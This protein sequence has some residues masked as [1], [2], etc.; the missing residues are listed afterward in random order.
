MSDLPASHS[1][2]FAEVLGHIQQTRQRVFAQANT[3]L[4][5][6]YWRMKQFSETYQGNAELSTLLRE[7][8]WSHNLAIFSRCKT[9]GDELYARALNLMSHETYSLY[10]P[11]E[12]VEDNKQLFRQILDAFLQRYKFELPDIFAQPAAKKA[13]APAP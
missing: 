7:L 11:V 2:D 10:Q 9:T 3:A 13:A 12:L 1:Q 5:D 6:L 8:P 4:I